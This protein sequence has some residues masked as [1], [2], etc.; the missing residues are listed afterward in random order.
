MAFRVTTYPPPPAIRSSLIKNPTDALPPIEDLE[1]LQADLKLLKLK[2]LERM[3]KAGDDLIAMQESFK[4]IKEREK[5]KGKAIEKIK[6]ERGSTPLL[7]GEDK[8]LTAQPQSLLKSRL[9]SVATSVAH[10]RVSSPPH[11]PRKALTDD[12]KKKKKKRKR[13]DDSEAESEP[14]KHR[15]TT[16]IPQNTHPHPPPPKPVKNPSTA[17]HSHSHGKAQTGPDFSLHAQIPLLPT[18]PP[19][20]SPPIPGPSKPTDVTDDFSRARPPNNQVTATTYYTSIE[21][22]LRPIKEE[23]IGFLEYTHD[24]VEPFIM[25]KLGRHY[26]EVWEEEDMAQYGFPLPG[27]A[28][29]RSGITLPGS[30]SM[31]PLPKWEPSQLQETDLVT[32]ERG[33]GPLT[34]RLVSAMIPLQNATEWK[35]V[36][37]AEEAMEGRPGTNGAAAQ[38]ARDKM[39]VYDLEERVKNVMRFHKLL[40]D[41]PDFSEAVDDPIATALRHAQKELRQ[42]VATNKARRARLTAIARDR[43]AYQEYVELRETLDKNISHQY[44]KLQKKENPRS[45][46]KKKKPEPNGTITPNGTVLPAPSPAALGLLQDEDLNLNVPEHLKHLVQTRRQWVDKIGAVFE[47]KERKNPG[48]IWGLS[49]SSIYEGV[50]EEV[51]QELERL[52]PPP[53]PG[54]RPQV[55]GAGPRINGVEKGKARA[56][57]EEVAMELG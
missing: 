4:R 5:G 47:E 46:K 57:V 19:I 33:H 45:H 2:A 8:R 12:A 9:S 25:P 53:R 28:A 51:Q 18:R 56:K 24:E 42:V 1:T 31:A 35:G 11:E 21:P 44:N 23:D 26:S 17:S 27:T 29:V 30:N 36:K 39:N 3:K 48:R 34:E 32:E 50:E 38:A 16:P 52:G 20:P 54:Q 13:D 41:L 14:V 15:K 22:Y 7:N 40:N 6:K 37:A 43:L 10:S 49:H 55:N